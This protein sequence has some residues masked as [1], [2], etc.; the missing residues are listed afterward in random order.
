MKLWWLP[1]GIVLTGVLAAG[2]CSTSAVVAVE[3]ADIEPVVRGNSAFAFD[4]YSQLSDRDG[5]LFLSPFSISSA[6]AMTYAGARGATAAEMAQVLHFARDQQDLDP[7]FGELLR[8]LRTES[9]GCEVHIAN[10]LWA[11]EGYAFLDTYLATGKT[12]YAAALNLVDYV[13]AAEA[14]RKTINGWVEDETRGKIADLI[15][16]GVLDA[17]TRLVLTN[18]IYFKGTWAQ[19]FEQA[20]TRDEDFWATA[21]RSVKTPMMHHT[22]QFGYFE[23]EDMQALELPYEGEALA[24]VVLL[25]R[26]RDGLRALEQSL[27]AEAFERWVN[28]LGRTEVIVSLPKFKM[29]SEFSLKDTLTSMGMP[30]AFGMRA[31]FSGMTGNTELFISAVIHKAYVDVNEEGTEAAAATGVVMQLKSVA[32]QPQPKVFRADHPFVFVIRDNR[33]GSIVFAGRLADPTT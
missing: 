16:P 26:R 13:K 29:T 25:P 30:L 33:T 8:Q 7:V 11:Q 22:G 20:N 1:I 32:V 17:M 21:E 28:G 18:A 4:L 27:T 24:M 10:A 5:N 23:N 12:H 9:E 31:D 2:A 19:E 6:L 15:P 14:A 3:R